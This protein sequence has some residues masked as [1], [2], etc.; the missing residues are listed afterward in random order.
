MAN[1]GNKEKQ[2]AIKKEMTRL[3]KLLQVLPGDR[4]QSAEGLIS[5]AAYMRAT[6]AELR[7]IIDR[8]GPVELFIQGQNE[9][10]REHPAVKS[11]NAMVQRYTNICK[12]LFD[13][14][15]KGEAKPEKDE[16]IDFVKAVK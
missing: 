8:D 7:E 14:L 16:L 4:L 1:N 11:Y 15:P 5:E 12:Q 10:N 3:K 9:Y 13:M 2:A 6:L